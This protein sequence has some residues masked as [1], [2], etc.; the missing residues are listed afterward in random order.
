MTFELID[1]MSDEPVWLQLY[2]LLRRGIEDGTYAPHTPASARQIQEESGLARATIAKAFDRL[3]DEGY[4]RIVPGRGPFV[5]PRQAFRT[6]PLPHRPATRESRAPVVDAQSNDRP[7]VLD[8]ADCG[9]PVPIMKSWRP[10]RP[11]PRSPGQPAGRAA[12]SW[13]RSTE[14]AVTSDGP[15]QVRLRPSTSAT[16][17]RGNISGPSPALNA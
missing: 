2:G 12:S 3:R 8:A 1:P 16:R 13:A 6:Q 15:Y 17:W 5:A 10:R 11:T 14:R 9:K 7:A 4:V